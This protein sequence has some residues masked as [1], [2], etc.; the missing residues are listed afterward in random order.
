MQPGR[1]FLFLLVGFGL[2]LAPG[3]TLAQDRDPL[4]IITQGKE[5]CAAAT[6]STACLMA[7]AE[8]VAAV[9]DALAEA[10]NSKD[11]GEFIAPVRALLAGGAGFFFGALWFG[12]GI[13][14]LRG[15]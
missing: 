2:G 3:L 11:R 1:L 5:V 14:Q 6:E 12:A 13:K 7:R 4:A 10:G 9:A 15:R 8:T